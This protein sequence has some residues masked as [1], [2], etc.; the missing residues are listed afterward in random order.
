M[1]DSAVLPV[2]DIRRRLRASAVKKLSAADT[3]RLAAC[4][5]RLGIDHADGD[6]VA[7]DR[8]NPHSWLRV[9]RTAGCNGSCAGDGDG[10]IDP[11][12]IADGRIGANARR[13]LP[14]P[15]LQLL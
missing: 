14:H 8:E 10:E 9:G 4:R 7:L 15:G 13:N 12:L 1:R 2:V 11:R 3:A 5:G 6:E